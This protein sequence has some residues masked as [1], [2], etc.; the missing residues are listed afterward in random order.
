MLGPTQRDL[1]RFAAEIRG[2]GTELEEWLEKYAGLRL[3]AARQFRLV[4]RIENDGEAPAQNVRLRVR[5]PEDF[6]RLTKPM[7]IDSAPSQPRFRGR[8]DIEPV[9]PL[10]SSALKE[11]GRRLTAEPTSGPVPIA[12][13]EDN[14]L[15]LTY[16][17]GHL[18]HGPDHMRTEPV[19]LLAPRDGDFDLRWEALSANPGPA[20]SGTLR[21]RVCPSVAVEP[22]IKTMEE[23]SDDMQNHHIEEA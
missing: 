13:H 19:T 18:N 3:Q 8:F 2:Y 4:F 7:A 12:S 10:R 17:I 11:I 9:V 16:E 6:Q 20:A 21:I 5:C 22:P 1:E 23:L 15:V 14:H